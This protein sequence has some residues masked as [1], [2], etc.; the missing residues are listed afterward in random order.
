MFPILMQG[1]QKV[2]K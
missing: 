2:C 1:H